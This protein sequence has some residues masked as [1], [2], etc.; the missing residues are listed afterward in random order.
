MRELISY[1]VF[2][3]DLYD[4]YSLTRGACFINDLTLV[5][6]AESSELTVRAGATAVTNLA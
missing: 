5:I 4:T 6:S 3:C 1:S 2:P